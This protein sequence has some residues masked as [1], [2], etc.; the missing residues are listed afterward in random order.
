MHLL[1]V[2]VEYFEPEETHGDFDLEF[3]FQNPGKNR[4]IQS[5]GVVKYD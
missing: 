4:D 5:L 1:A 3:N 2:V